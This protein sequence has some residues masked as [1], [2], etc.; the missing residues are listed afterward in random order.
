MIE[1]FKYILIIE[2]M[3]ITGLDIPGLFDDNREKLAEIKIKKLW[4]QMWERLE[5]EGYYLIGEYA[6]DLNNIYKDVVFYEEITWDE[7]LIEE[8]YFLDHYFASAREL[9]KLIRSSENNIEYFPVLVDILGTGFIKQEDI[10]LSDKEYSQL[11]MK[12]VLSKKDNS[13]GDD[14]SYKKSFIHRYTNIF[15]RDR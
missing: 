9:V 1:Y 8:E 14:Y 5:E 2:N 6:E 7:L 3:S 10:E 13:C 11:R 12:Y 4:E 15:S